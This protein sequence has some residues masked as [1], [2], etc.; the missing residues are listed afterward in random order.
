[1]DWYGRYHHYSFTLYSFAS[2]IA[3]HV[4]ASSNTSIQLTFILSLSPFDFSLCL[5]NLRL[6]LCFETDFDL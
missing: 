4:F 2:T 5:G 1:M 6:L 3:A